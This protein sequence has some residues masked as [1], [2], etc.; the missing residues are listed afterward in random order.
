LEDRL[1]DLDVLIVRLVRLMRRVLEGQAV[2]LRLA[3][4]GEEQNRARV[5]CL[6]REEQVQEDEGLRVEVEEEDRV[7]DHPRCDSDGLDDEKRPRADACGDLVGRRSP[8]VASSWWTTLT[9][10]LWS[11]ELYLRRWSV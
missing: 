9:G 11:S 3:V 8:S 7:A 6:D 2:L 1:Q 4:A 5:G 10:C